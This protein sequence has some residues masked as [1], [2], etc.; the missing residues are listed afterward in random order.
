MAQQLL[1]SAA[2]IRADV[3]GPQSVEYGLGL[4]R[5]ADLERRRHLK[6]SAEDFYTRAAQILGDRPEAARALMYLGATAVMNK[7]FAR[8]IEYFQHAQRVDPT[9]AGAALMWMAIVRQGEQNA[10]EAE[11]LFKNC[12][13]VQD[14]K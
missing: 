13:S 12:L 7:D 1:T 5:L 9:K 8:A 4:L 3:S 6:N 11:T 14:P 2:A 10:D